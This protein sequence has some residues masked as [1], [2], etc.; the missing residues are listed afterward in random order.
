V[1]HHVKELMFTVR[2]GAADPR[3]GAML[4]EQFG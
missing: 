1:D 4:L 3:F 2:I